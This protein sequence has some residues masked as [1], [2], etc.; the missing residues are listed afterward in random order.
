MRHPENL[1]DVPE[2]YTD[3][4]FGREELCRFGTNYIERGGMA[5]RGYPSFSLTHWLSAL[6]RFRAKS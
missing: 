4:A 3:R 6:K 5:S 1:G 2:R